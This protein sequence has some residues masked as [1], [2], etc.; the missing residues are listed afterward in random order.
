MVD[1]AYPSQTEWHPYGH[2]ICTPVSLLVG[3]TFLQTQRQNLKDVLSVPCVRNIMHLSH[4]LYRDHFA[5]SGLPLKI[6]ELFPY[7][8]LKIFKYTE[9]AGM[10]WS[11]QGLQ[12]AEGMIIKPLLEMLENIVSESC[13]KGERVCLITTA[14][15]HTVCYC[16]DEE[17]CLFVFDPL[18]A[19]MQSIQVD[20]LKAW[21]RKQYHSADTVY[22]ALLL[23]LIP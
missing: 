19:S 7:I 18:P 4:N 22:S 11:H 1:E 12:E 23:S 13:A 20:K 17:G 10:A 2:L 8:S 5:A 9:V 15:E 16:V 3:A 6:Q 14:E 21:L